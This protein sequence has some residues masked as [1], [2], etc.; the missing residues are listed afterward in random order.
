MKK[1]LLFLSLLVLGMSAFSQYPQYFKEI[2]K[3]IPSF[4]TSI[5]VSDSVAV[6]SAGWENTSVANKAGA[7]YVYEY[8]GADWVETQRLVSPQGQYDGIFGLSV[9]TNGKYIVV[10]EPN[11]QKA[12]IFK[13]GDSEW[14]IDKTFQV[15][16]NSAERYGISCDIDENTVAIGSGGIFAVFGREAVGSVYVYE[17]DNGEWENTS[18]LTP[19]DGVAHDNMGASVKVKDNFIFAGANR[20]VGYVGEQGYVCIFEKDTDSWNFAQKIFAPDGTSG[21]RFGT[22]IDVDDNHNLLVSC[23]GAAYYFTKETSWILKQKLESPTG[24]LDD[25]FGAPVSMDN[26]LIMVSATADDETYENSGAVYLY[27]NIGPEYQ[28]VSKILP[29]DSWENRRFSSNSLDFHRNFAFISGGASIGTLDIYQLSDSDCIITDTIQVI[30]HDT[31]VTQLTDTTFL[32]VYDTIPVYDSIPV[33]D[34]IPVND[35]IPVY[36]YISVTDTLVIDAVL[37]GLNPPGNLN[38]LKV[39]PNPAKD[40]IFINTGDYTKMDRYQLKIINQLGSVVFE[41][42]V[43]EPLY[44]VNL[45]SWSGMGLYFLHVIDADGKII[46]IRKIILQ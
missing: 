20:A 17:N 14:V 38:R 9:A 22:F 15:T 35:T 13:R 29:D 37:T 27:K 19:P 31:I 36:E 45:S 18:I 16:D 1:H 42:R 39:Y 6:V 32:T 43:E 33:Y 11:A 7:A 25:G 28:Q 21:N 5:S 23:S 30:H 41:T 3:E 4:P 10:T 8:D 40:F 34:T 24:T 46:D 12:H 26:N 2:K 44:E